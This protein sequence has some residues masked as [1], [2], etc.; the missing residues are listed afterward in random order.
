MGEPSINSTERSGAS[1]TRPKEA[2]PQGEERGGLS[3]A[4]V[5]SFLKILFITLLI[6]LFLKT[7]VIEA[8]RIP[9]GS[10]ENTLLVGDFLFV[11]KFVYG[12]R[13]PRYVPLTNLAIP[14]I[15]FP[16]FKQVRRGDV[17]VFEFPGDRE[18]LSD[19]E[20]VNYVKRCIGLPGDTIRMLAERV[21]VN[22]RELLLP[23]HAKVIEGGYGMGWREE[24]DLFPPGSKF[25][26][27][28]YG[29]LVVPKRGDRIELNS[30]TFERWK[31]LIEKEGH[32]AE[33]TRDGTVLIDGAPAAN[34]SIERNYYFVLGDNRDNSLDSRYWGFVPDGNLI[35]EALIIY[36]SWDTELA[37]NGL[38]DRFKMIR[39]KR[40][41]SLIR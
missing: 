26:L 14:S 23:P 34:Y 30:G 6:V 39:W 32:S 9:S 37:G 13:T 10:M 31:S 17:I 12:L 28:N 4:R 2:V 29:P 8:Y 1:E 33:V 25:T 20:S 24:T 18:K 19:P 41:G 40:I 3:R 5:M 27:D 11:N 16:A 38:W 36:W 15:A 35:G 7:F 22:G 21:F